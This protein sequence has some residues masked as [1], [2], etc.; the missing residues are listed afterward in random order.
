MK[1]GKPRRSCSTGRG[2][3][4]SPDDQ[5]VAASIFRALAEARAGESRLYW[6]TVG[7]PL[8]TWWVIAFA[9]ATPFTV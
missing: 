4:A 3:V 5:Q 1:A 2:H 7:E 9:C 6:Q 8:N